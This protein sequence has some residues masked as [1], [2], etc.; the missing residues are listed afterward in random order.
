MIL[1]APLHGSSKYIMMWPGLRQYFKLS[2][3]SM[4]HNLTQQLFTCI[5]VFGTGP[6]LILGSVKISKSVFRTNSIL[7]LPA[8]SLLA[9]KRK[10]STELGSRSL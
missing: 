1:G 6:K 8:T 3:A 4:L 2:A 7:N 5:F 9:S 10:P